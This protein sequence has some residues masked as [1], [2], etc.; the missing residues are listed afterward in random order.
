MIIP[1]AFLCHAQGLPLR[2]KQEHTPP[3]MNV[4]VGTVEDWIIEN[5]SQE[6]HVFHIRATRSTS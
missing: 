5:Y 6:L 2:T 4:Q 3:Q 1:L